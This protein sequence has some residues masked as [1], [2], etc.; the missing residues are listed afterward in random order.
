MMIVLTCA[1]VVV[2]ECLRNVE[3]RRVCRC[4]DFRELGVECLPAW[5]SNMLCS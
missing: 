5:R 4:I 3:C 1:A 2:G